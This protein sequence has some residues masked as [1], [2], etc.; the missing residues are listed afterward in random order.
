MGAM[1]IEDGKVDILNLGFLA[2]DGV[3][4]SDLAVANAARV[5]F[6]QV[7]QEMTE[8]DVGLINFLMRERHGTPF[9]HGFFRFIMKAPI[10]VAREHHR[11]RIGHSYNEWS[12]RYSKL[13]SEFYIPR[14]VRTQVGKPGC[15]QYL[16]MSDE[17]SRKVREEIELTAG[18]A[19]LKYDSL[20]ELGVAKEV[21]RLVLPLATYTKYYWS[22]NPRSL[23][24][25]CSLRNSLNAQ[26]EIMEYAK[27]AEL[28]FK[29][30]MPITFE[31]FIKNGRVSP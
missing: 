9:E 10:F 4:A 25:F 15:Y 13:D 27:A 5:S 31:A 22:C 16:P 19:F 7:S 20:L 28:F 24:H 3:F 8:K 29:D 14:Y 2:L 18:Q 17:E 6:N 21:A 11:H 26:Y 1:M 12:G 30:A 23:M